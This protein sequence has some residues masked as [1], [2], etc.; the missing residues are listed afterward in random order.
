MTHTRRIRSHS[1]TESAFRRRPGS[2]GS[3]PEYDKQLS[4]FHGSF[5][6]ELQAIVNELPLNP[7]MHVLDLACGDGFY[8]RRIADRLGP[9]GSITGVDIN[10]A[11]LTEAGEEVSC[12]RGRAKIDFIAAS[13]DRLPF[14][15]GTFDLV[16]CAQS[17][18]TLPDPVAAIRHMVRVVRRGGVIAVLENDTLHEVCL[19]W[20]VYLELPL[21]AAELRFFLEESQN[22]SKYYVGR[23]L[24]HVL[25]E[26]GLEPLGLTTHAFDRQ[27]PLGEAEKALL[28]GYLKT[29]VARV[30]PYLELEL[31][32][33]LHQLVDPGSPT[34]MLQQPQLTM[35]WLNVLALGRKPSV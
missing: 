24:P 25:A 10:R 32:K 17:L 30:S 18:F 22:S 5:E 15:D 23:R 31:L 27:A 8:T 35:T 16:W 13:F 14:R 34:N 4:D 11:Y 19:P 7:N 28:R 20:P 12:Q 3:L 9:G 26:A 2:N 1:S 29:V 33:E 6:H 21:R